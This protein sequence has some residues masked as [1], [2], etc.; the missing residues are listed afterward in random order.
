MQEWL[1]IKQIH[2]QHPEINRKLIQT[3]AREEL[4]PRN[5]ARKVGG[6]RRG[7]WLILAE[8]V[9]DLANDLATRTPGTSP[10][11]PTKAERK[12]ADITYRLNGSVASV[13]RH[14]NIRWS[15]AKA[16]LT[17]IYNTDDVEL[18]PAHR[19]PKINP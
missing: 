8:I 15:R 4:A 19:E 17:E 10:R 6:E 12:K 13:A 7:T 3:V 2:E 14:F 9:P 16:W 1:T 18:W 11:K 5:L